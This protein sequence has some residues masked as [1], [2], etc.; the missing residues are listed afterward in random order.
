M[1]ARLDGHLAAE[2]ALRA[3]SHCKLQ[4]IGEAPQHAE[5]GHTHARCARPHGQAIFSKGS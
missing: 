3:A 4:A 2:R 5:L 1:R